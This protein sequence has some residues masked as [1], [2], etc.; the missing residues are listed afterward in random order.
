MTYAKEGRFVYFYALFNKNN[1]L[2]K[3]SFKVNA[4]YNTIEAYYIYLFDKIGNI[5][6]KTI[7]EEV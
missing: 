7:K 5:V 6:I 2:F 3:K 4:L 1:Y